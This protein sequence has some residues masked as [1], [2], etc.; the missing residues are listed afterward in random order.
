MG[1]Y[2]GSNPNS[3][4]VLYEIQRMAVLMRFELEK[5]NIDDVLLMMA[6]GK[7]TEGLK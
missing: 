5:G 7:K 6:K 3:I 2:I 1:G 4:E